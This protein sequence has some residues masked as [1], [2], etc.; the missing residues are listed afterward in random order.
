MT[1][2]AFTAGTASTGGLAG[3]RSAASPHAPPR[4]TTFAA[5][6]LAVPGSPRRRAKLWELAASVHC[7]VIG[8]CLTTGELRRVMG[9][10]AKTDVSHLSDHDLHSEAVGHCARHNACSKLLGKA[11]DERHQGAI[12]RLARLDGEAA[13]LEAWREARGDGDIP[14]AYWAVLTHPDTGHAGMRQAFGDVH[15][16]SHLVGSANRADVRRLSVLEA[17][18]AA[19]LAKVERQQQRLREAVTSRDE[20]IRQLGALAATQAR[21]ATEEPGAED[22]LAAFRHLVG[23]LQARLAAEIGRRERLE[24]RLA[25]ASGTGQ[26]WERRAVAAEAERDALAREVAMLEH[27][28]ACPGPRAASPPALPPERILYVGGRPGCVAQMRA[29]LTVAGGELLAHDAGRHEHPSLLAGLISQADR[30]VFPV[31]CVSHDAALAVK[32]LCRQLG[33]PWSPLRSSGLASFLAALSAPAPA[34]AV[35]GSMAATAQ[36]PSPQAPTS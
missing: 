16:L 23:D 34:G 27:P 25:G 12:K 11:L 1:G 10:F 20:T 26:G 3:L 17:E 14:G 36:S 9:R 4:A 18:K 28:D 6:P 35:P 5:P 31:D 32:R 30:V 22:A 2:L 33:K 7:S 29:A 21:T 24:A 13:V 8:T 15:M 19:L